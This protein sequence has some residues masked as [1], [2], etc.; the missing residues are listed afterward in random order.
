MG[1]DELPRATDEDRAHF[2]AIARAMREDEDERIA[3][4]LDMTPGQR[5][6]LGFELAAEAPWTPARLAELD[7]ETDGE[8]ELARLRVARG[9]GRTA[10]RS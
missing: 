5:I 9:L 6:L 1:V 10:P 8:I 7:A 3:R 2:A 4:A